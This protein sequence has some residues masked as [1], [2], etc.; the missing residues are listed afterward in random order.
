MLSGVDAHVML[1]EKATYD[2]DL[3][4]DYLA[5]HRRVNDC[6]LCGRPRKDEL[7]QMTVQRA[8]EVAQ[9]GLVQTE[10]GS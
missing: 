7:H 3:P 1:I 4:H 9:S 6:G 8:A 5:L 2:P 10:K